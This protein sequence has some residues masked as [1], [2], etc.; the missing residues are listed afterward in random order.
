MTAITNQKNSWHK[1][2]SAMLAEEYIRFFMLLSV[3]VRAKR[4]SGL[5][6][7]IFVFINFAYQK[8]GLKKH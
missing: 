5:T 1:K 8:F 3:A 7:Q 6:E 4:I 2:V